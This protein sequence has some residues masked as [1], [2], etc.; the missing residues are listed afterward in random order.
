MGT[1]GSISYL[2]QLQDPPQCL[3]HV[4]QLGMPQLLLVLQ[5]TQV[6]QAPL[7]TVPACLHQPWGEDGLVLGPSLG[8]GSP[9]IPA[10]PPSSLSPPL[11][12]GDSAEHLWHP[13]NFLKSINQIA[14][15]KRCSRPRKGH[16][17]GGNVRKGS[18]GSWED[19][20][21]PCIDLPHIQSL[22]EEA[23]AQPPQ[24][25]APRA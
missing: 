12:R 7:P 21:S 11:G 4:P 9:F 24:K 14:G 22:A 16:W 17:R 23:L 5:L 18:M 8:N 25:Q 20:A 6:V 15:A 10:L 13:A 2:G 19:H 3:P 1:L